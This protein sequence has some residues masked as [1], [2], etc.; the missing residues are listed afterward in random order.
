MRMGISTALLFVAGLTPRAASA[1]AVCFS[2]TDETRMA[3]MLTT[4]FLTALP[5]AMVGSFAFWLRGRWRRQQIALPAQRDLLLR[6]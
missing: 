4:I 2:G 3:F 6:R 5:L 1:C